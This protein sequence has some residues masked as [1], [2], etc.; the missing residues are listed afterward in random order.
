MGPCVVSDRGVGR[1]D[2]RR[3]PWRLALIGCGDVKRGERDWRPGE[4]GGGVAWS[5]RRP[6]GGWNWRH[7]WRSVR[8]HPWRWLLVHPWSWGGGAGADGVGSGWEGCCRFWNRSRSQLMVSNCSSATAARDS[9]RASIRKKYPPWEF[10]FD[11][12]AIAPTVQVFI[13]LSCSSCV[14][15]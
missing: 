7:P 11:R 6:G 9:L 5:E 3:H 1:C 13:V 15:K 2:R 4:D 14:W 12:I 8:R 10:P